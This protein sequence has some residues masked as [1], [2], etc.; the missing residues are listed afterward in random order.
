MYPHFEFH[1]E[2]GCL[3]PNEEDVK[4][5]T[6]EQRDTLMKAIADAGYIFDF[7][8]KKLKKKIAYEK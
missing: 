6:K 2:K 8:K 7:D 3:A 5:A 1:S 4:P